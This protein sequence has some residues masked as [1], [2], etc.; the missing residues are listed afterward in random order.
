MTDQEQGYFPFGGGK[1]SCPGRSYAFVQTLAIVMAL[2]GRFDIR[3]EDGGLIK[4]P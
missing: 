1:H 2:I 4:V 3:G